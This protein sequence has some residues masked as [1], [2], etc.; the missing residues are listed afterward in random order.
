MKLPSAFRWCL[1]IKQNHLSARPQ[2]SLPQ[3]TDHGELV[4]RPQVQAGKEKVTQEEK[5]PRAFWP[6]YVTT[7]Y[8]QS[9]LK[10]DRVHTTS[11]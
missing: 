2:F 7:L 9:L 11:I 10:P 8:P 6:L 5:G 1:L 4:M 3:S